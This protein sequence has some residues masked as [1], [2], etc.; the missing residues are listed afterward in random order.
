MR[1]AL[2]EHQG[3]I[4]PVF[5]TCRRLMVF[6]DT[7]DAYESLSDE[8]WSAVARWNR[9]EWLWRLRIDLLM[10]G[11]ISCWMEEQILQ[12]GILMIPWLAGY[13]P[14]ILEALRSETI[15][16]P[17]YAMPGSRRCRRRRGIGMGHGQRNR[18]FEGRQTK[19]KGNARI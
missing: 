4:A 17:R 5:D 18:P 6:V 7:G 16:D 9:P 19:E 2:P 15:D 14:E 12:R 11:G 3:R 1:V 8:D 13:V 10:C